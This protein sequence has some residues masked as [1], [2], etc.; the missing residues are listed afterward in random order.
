MINVDPY[1]KMYPFVKSR[2]KKQKVIVFDFDE[3]IGSFGHLYSLWNSIG[4]SYNGQNIG[5]E[6]N[7]INSSI[8]SSAN[9]GVSFEP[10][11]SLHDSLVKE[12]SANAGVS[13]ELFK[14]IMDMYPEFLRYG[15][16]IILEYI[17]FK[18]RNGKC[19]KVFIYTNNQCTIEWVNMIV[20]Y[21]HYKIP[22]IVGSPLIDKIILAFKIN[23]KV[24]QTDRTTNHKTYDDFIKCSVISNTTEICFI[25]DTYHSS[26]M[27]KKIYYIQPRPYYHNLTK[28]IIL[29]RLFSSDVLSNYSNVI[30]NKT[31]ITEKFYNARIC[32]FY[33]NEEDKTI[34][35][36]ISKRLMYCIKDFFYINTSEVKTQKNKKIG[37]F[38]RKKPIKN[39]HHSSAFLHLQ[40]ESI[41]L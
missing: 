37:R 16:L 14:K 13:F 9:A 39:Q 29:D 26:M 4:F 15:I 20:Q 25:D 5:N 31:T 12:T 22:I 28:K 35:I 3:T 33:K 34:D 23:N 30:N 38:T 32:D 2:K 18:K 7:S 40:L 8:N 27:N 6:Q 21:I 17:Y 41:V 36:L 1:I 24:V 10:S 11:K 19:Y